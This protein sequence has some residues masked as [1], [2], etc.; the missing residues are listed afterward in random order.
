MLDVHVLLHPYTSRAWQTQCLNSAHEA[1]DHAGYPVAV[2][3][4]PAVIGHIG[5]AR[6]QG[7]AMGSH[8]YMTSVDDDDWLE[9]D[10]F[11]VLA[12]SLRKHV[13]AVYTHAWTWQNG[14]RLP[15]ELRQH[16]RVFRR[17]VAAGFDFAAWP[18]CDSTALI[19]HADTFGPYVTIAMPVYNY[20]LHASHARALH[21]RYPGVLKRARALGDVHLAR[22]A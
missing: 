15:S 3:T 9:P 11:A 21:K 18:I 10:A 16:L 2:H 19:A 22:A 6:A 5:Q 14:K 8:P 17:D 20:R 4:L 7:Y 1:A 12:D 13:P